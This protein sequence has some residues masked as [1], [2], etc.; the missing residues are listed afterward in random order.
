[1]FFRILYFLLLWSCCDVF[2]T[3]NLFVLGI[4]PLTSV[5]VQNLKNCCLAESWSKFL[6]CSSLFQLFAQ[7]MLKSIFWPAFGVCNTQTLV[8]IYN[9][10]HSNQRRY[11]FWNTYTHTLSLSLLYCT[12]NGYKL[13]IV[14]FNEWWLMIQSLITRRVVLTIPISQILDFLISLFL[15]KLL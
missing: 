12:I 5:L 11:T 15:I 6:T 8:K 4:K 9:K 10:Y 14:R 7:K 2:T 3:E 1:M 13:L